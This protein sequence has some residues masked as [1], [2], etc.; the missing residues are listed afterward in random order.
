MKL[1]DKNRMKELW[2]RNKVK[3][4]CGTGAVIGVAGLIIGCK[5]CKSF[6]MSNMFGSVTGRMP[7]R[8]IPET[9]GFKILDI[10]ED[11]RDGCVTWLDG[12]KLA[13]CGK[14]GDGLSKIERVDPETL[15]TMVI[16]AK[17]ELEL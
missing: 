2:E 17:E 11:V 7:S 3:I 16:L 12:C 4:I 6:P 14:L 13:D 9:D 8:P 1:C 5:H 10:G 15:V